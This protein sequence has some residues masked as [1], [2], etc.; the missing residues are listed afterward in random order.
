MA[1]N[2]ARPPHVVGRCTT[3]T[4]EHPKELAPWVEQK[5]VRHRRTTTRASN[6]LGPPNPTKKLA[7]WVDLL[8][9]P[10]SRNHVWNFQGWTLPPALT[11][12]TLL[13]NI[14]LGFGNSKIILL[15]S[16]RDYTPGLDPSG[17]LPWKLLV[18]PLQTLLQ[19]SW[20]CFELAPSHSQTPCRPYCSLKKNPGCGPDS[21]DE[22]KNHW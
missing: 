12:K 17:A 7:H 6:G 11:L 8:S 4:R 19:L 14:I 13:F 20:R 15:F 9:H 3:Y 18:T 5:L 2:W 10:L 21:D 16:I 22:K 1:G